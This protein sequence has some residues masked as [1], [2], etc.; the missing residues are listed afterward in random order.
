MATGLTCTESQELLAL[1]A[2]GVLQAGDSAQL[3]SHLQTC[4]DCRAAGRDLRNAAAMLPE[5]LDL[6]QPPASLR[7]T[8]LAEVYTGAP[9]RSRSSAWWRSLWRRVPAGRPLTLVAAGAAVAAVVLGIWGA[10]RS[11]ALSP[12]SYTVVGTTS[13]PSARGT[14]VYYPSTTES[15]VTVT[16]LPQPASAVY[17]LWLIP[18]GGSPHPAGF[19]VLSPATHVWTAAIQADLSQF[20]SVAATAE[21]P[22]GSAKPTGAQL[23][24]VPLTQ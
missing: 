9:R 11:P 3:E 7:R 24:S 1:A 14:L 22:G 12:R 8:L 16:G 10:T 2:L 23:F 5:A 15:V 18:S 13:E 20:G 21:P 6:L 17:E 19:L 4:V